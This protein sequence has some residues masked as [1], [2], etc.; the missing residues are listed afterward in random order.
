MK[1]GLSEELDKRNFVV[2]SSASLQASSASLFWVGQP[3]RNELM[4]SVSGKKYPMTL[5]LGILSYTKVRGDSWLS[6]AHN[7]FH[8]FLR[9]PAYLMK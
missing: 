9:N 1:R 3:Q 6:A 4:K 7:H 5:D 8:S 2:G